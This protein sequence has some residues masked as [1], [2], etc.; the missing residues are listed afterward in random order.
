M[1]RKVVLGYDAVM[2]L[3]REAQATAEE[4]E[5]IKK[6]FHDYDPDMLS[7]MPHMEKSFIFEFPLRYKPTA[8]DYIKQILSHID[9][10]EQKR[11]EKDEVKEEKKIGVPE[12]IEILKKAT[13]II[14]EK[15]YSNEIKE[16]EEK[17]TKSISSETVQLLEEEG[18]IHPALYYIEKVKDLIE[19]VQRIDSVEKIEKIIEAIEENLQK[20]KQYIEK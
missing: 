1:T 11:K 2:R 7:K 13:L 14:I 8:R 12:K 15:K 20:A 16:L 5:K 3:A 9:Y 4:I 17:I 10:L 18:L 6:Y 19:F